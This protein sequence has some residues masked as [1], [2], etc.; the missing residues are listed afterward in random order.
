MMV[1]ILRKH[2]GQV[3]VMQPISSLM[4]KAQVFPSFIVGSLL[5]PMVGSLRLFSQMK[6]L[7][8]V[9]VVVFHLI[10]KMCRESNKRV[11]CYNTGWV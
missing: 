6:G 10:L 1:L 4:V 8:P 5:D 3:K 9:T 11:Q 7:R 2:K